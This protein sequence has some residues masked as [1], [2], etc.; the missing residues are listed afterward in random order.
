MINS[1]IELQMTDSLD[2]PTEKDCVDFYVNTQGEVIIRTYSGE[3]YKLYDSRTSEVVLK[4]D[5]NTAGNPVT[6]DNNL[7]IPVSFFPDEIQ[8]KS[9]KGKADGY[10][11]L[12][13]NSKIPLNQLPD[14][15]QYVSEKARPNGYASLDNYGKIPLN[16]LP[17]G[18][19]SK[20]N[21]NEPNGYAGINYEGKIES[22]ILPDSLI[23]Y[24]SPD[25]LKTI[26]N[27]AYPPG[28]LYCN[29]FYKTNPAEI[30][31]VGNWL[32]IGEN[33]H[34]VADDLNSTP[35]QFELNDYE[36][37]NAYQN[38]SGKF[39]INIDNLPKHRHVTGGFAAA[40]ESWGTIIFGWTSSNN[41]KD[42]QSYKN[43]VNA[44]AKTNTDE[45]ANGYG[46]LGRGKD[47]PNESSSY[48]FADKN[49]PTNVVISSTQIEEP[50]TQPVPIDV[51]PKAIKMFI[52]YR[53]P[54]SV[55]SETINNNLQTT[56]AIDY[57]GRQ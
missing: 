16:Q 44:I 55:T 43:Y 26:N 30:L 29:F 4:K 35:K 41:L 34:I 38:P 28:S 2:Y 53:L 52:W 24:D 19:E 20:S 1:S 8:L 45:I 6:T 7:K 39:V 10:A 57:P 56:R 46:I 27:I 5:L 31:G 18:V 17:D 14:D 3:E 23:Y 51:V 22:Y 9:E 50:D 15:L 13:S 48:E 21:K 33:N 40:N 36:N 37:T 12:D 25:L 54:E 32:Y 47:F 11:S 42:V 49:Q